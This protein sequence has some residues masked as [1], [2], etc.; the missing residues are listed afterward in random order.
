M[1]DPMWLHLSFGFGCHLCGF[2]FLQRILK[3]HRVQRTA[4]FAASQDAPS[5]TAFHRSIA[6]G[7]ALL[8]S[9]WSALAM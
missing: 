5:H 1:S 2:S 8:V 6:Q 3:F 4:F 9:F 7:V